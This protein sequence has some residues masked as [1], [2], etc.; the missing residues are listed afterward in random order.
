M[1]ASPV[2]PLDDAELGR[3][4]ESGVREVKSAAR[5]VELLELLASRQNRPARLRELADALGVPRSSLYALLR[6]LVR[7]GWVAT[8]ASG[9]LYRIGI[10]ALLVGTSYL[11][12]DPYLR[13]IQPYIDEL[14]ESIDETFHIGRLDGFDIVY[15]AT[16]ESSQY[17]R[18]Y[19]RVGRRL[20][21]YATSLGK[22]ILAEREGADRSEHIPAELT[23]LT[24]HTITD[25]QQLEADLALA[26]ERGYA[27]DEQENSLGLRCFAVA[28]R[29]SAPAVDALSTSVPLARLTPERETEIISAL[30]RARDHIER[31]VAPL[32]S[33]A[34]GLV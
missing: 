16:R 28:L 34:A 12:A 19:S 9:T 4:A 29:Y 33:L 23:A 6:T 24:T 10:H 2:E 26:R 11:D 1:A 20:P 14:G 31:S 22:A 27:V 5:T 7:C 32:A 18:P 15:L 21:A 17:L 13:L 8:D 30:M 25:R 3:V